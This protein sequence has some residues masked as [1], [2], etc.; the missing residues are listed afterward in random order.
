MEFLIDTKLL[1][2]SVCQTFDGPGALGA[3]VLHWAV[4]VEGYSSKVESLSGGRKARVGLG[5]GSHSSICTNLPAD[6]VRCPL[7]SYYLLPVFQAVQAA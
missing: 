4:E 5:A 2:I 3:L 6:V 7:T 1:I